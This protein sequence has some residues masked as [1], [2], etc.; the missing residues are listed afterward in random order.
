M[1]HV[2]HLSGIQAVHTRALSPRRGV[3]NVRVRRRV[4]DVVSEKS[5]KVRRTRELEEAGS[6][7][8]ARHCK[9]AKRYK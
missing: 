1:Q 7:A 4:E 8:N 5:E 3:R 9:V 2:L 6:R